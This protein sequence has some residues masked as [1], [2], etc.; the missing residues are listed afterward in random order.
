[1]RYLVLILMLSASVHAQHIGYQRVS[2]IIPK[3]I[4]IKE[5][6]TNMKTQENSKK[7]EIPLLINKNV[8]PSFLK[9]STNTNLTVESNFY[10]ANFMPNEL[11][12]RNIFSANWLKNTYNSAYSEGIIHTPENAYKAFALPSVSSFR[13]T[14]E[15]AFSDNDMALVYTI[16]AR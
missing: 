1:M 15:L 2:L 5:L 4:S 9:I 16:T 10:S 14:E 12:K 3:C 6:D 13:P 8:Q 11:N 7:I